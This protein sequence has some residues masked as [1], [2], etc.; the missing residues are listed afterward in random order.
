MIV[1]GGAREGGAW[2]LVGGTVSCVVWEGYSS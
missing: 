1:G 2:W